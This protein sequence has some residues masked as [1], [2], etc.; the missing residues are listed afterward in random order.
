MSIHH[1]N[2]AF[3]MASVSLNTVV[4]CQHNIICTFTS[5]IKQQIGLLKI[6]SNA[7]IFAPNNTDVCN[8]DFKDSTCLKRFYSNEKKAYL[9]IAQGIN[10]DF[11]FVDGYLYELYKEKYLNFTS[12]F[13]EAYANG[14]VFKI[15]QSNETFVYEQKL[16]ASKSNKCY[17]SSM[18]ECSCQN[19]CMPCNAAM[20]HLIIEKNRSNECSQHFSA[21]F[22]SKTVFDGL[23]VTNRFQNKH[24]MDKSFEPIS[25]FCVKF[26]TD[27]IFFKLLSEF[28]VAKSGNFVKNYFLFRIFRIFSPKCYDVDLDIFKFYSVSL[29]LIAEIKIPYLMSSI[30]IDGISISKKRHYLVEVQYYDSNGAAVWDKK[31]LAYFDSNQTENCSQ[32]NPIFDSILNSTRSNVS[33]IPGFYFS[34]ANLKFNLEDLKFPLGFFECQNEYVRISTI[35]LLLIILSILSI[36]FYMAFSLKRSQKKLIES[37]SQKKILFYV[38]IRSGSNLKQI[39]QQFCDIL[40]GILKRIN[41]E[42]MTIT[43]RICERAELMEKSDKIFYICSEYEFFKKESILKIGKTNFDDEFTK[44]NFVERFK[45]KT[46]KI[47]FRKFLPEKI[48]SSHKNL[49]LPKDIRK[50]LNIVRDNINENNSKKL[51]EKLNLSIISKKISYQLSKFL[52]ENKDNHSEEPEIEPLTCEFVSFEDAIN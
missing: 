50:F 51:F 13:K 3:F 15:F 34:Y 5:K 7:E 21:Y 31:L 44:M 27:I 41:I 49:I 14:L 52:N 2:Y 24:I 26:D 4:E 11:E 45:D 47:L 9:V 23:P 18:G 42:I 25:S 28:N 16:R 32:K 17:K 48:H 39:T 29:E 10:S 22:G 38:S 40:S 37:Y 8:G 43:T 36:L 46:T 20:R 1:Q 12:K 6:N 19:K 30:K 33:F 35:F